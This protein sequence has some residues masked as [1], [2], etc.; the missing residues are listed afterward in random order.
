MQTIG[1]T[2]RQAYLST[3]LL[4]ARGYWGLNP[5]DSEMEAKTF[6]ELWQQDFSTRLHC[7]L[8]SPDILRNFNLV[9][10]P[11]TSWEQVSLFLLEIPVR[12]GFDA[13]FKRL[14][15]GEKRSRMI[16]GN[17][18]CLIVAVSPMRGDIILSGAHIFV[19]G[20]KLLTSI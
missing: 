19:R 6:H 4:S 10:R 17:A 18:T 9:Y 11:A 20:S 2:F 12:K 14:R 16:A 3:L 8:L 7:R 13:N 15:L 1:S 5:T